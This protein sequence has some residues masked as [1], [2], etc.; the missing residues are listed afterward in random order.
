MTLIN[1]YDHA[2]QVKIVTPHGPDYVHIAPKRRVVL[3]AEYTVDANFAA[4]HPK[5]SIVEAE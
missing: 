4:T 3:D 5:L 1:L 2:L